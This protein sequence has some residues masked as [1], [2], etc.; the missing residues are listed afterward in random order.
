M[1]GV[2]FIKHRSIEILSIDFSYCTSREE[3]LRII[4]ETKIL[5]AT[6]PP[7]SVFTLTDITDAYFDREISQ[8]LKHL[9]AYNKPY[10][11]AGGSCRHNSCSRNYLQRRNVFLQTPS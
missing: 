6:R 9:A 3:I 10:V 5:I 8:A 1:A 2:Q 4:E 11:K 7:S